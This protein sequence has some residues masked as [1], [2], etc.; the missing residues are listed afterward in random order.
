M[1]RA[2]LKFESITGAELPDY[3]K[4]KNINVLIVRAGADWKGYK[5]HNISI[6]DVIYYYYHDARNI[7]SGL[8]GLGNIKGDW[9]NIDYLAKECLEVFKVINRTALERTGKKFGMELKN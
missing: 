2:E 7:T 4:A 5:N 6:A 1:T 3:I 9:R 8:R